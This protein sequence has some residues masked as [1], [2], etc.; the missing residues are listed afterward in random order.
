MRRR[1][2][3]L[4]GWTMTDVVIILIAGLIGIITLYPI[5]YVIS[6]SVSKPNEVLAGHVILF[7]KGFTLDAYRIVLAND[8]YFQA[9]KMTVFY[10]AVTV[11]LRVV[12]AVLLG[13]PMTRKNLKGRKYLNYYLLIPMYFGAG[14]IPQFIIVAKVLGLYNN[15]WG[16]LLPGLSIYEAILV[17]TFIKSLGDE[18]MDSAMIDGCSHI[19]TLTR[20]VFPLIK[21][22]VAVIS[23]WAIVGTWNSWFSSSVYLTNAKLHPVQMYMKKILSSLDAVKNPTLMMTL[24]YEERMRLQEMANSANQIRYAMIVFTVAPILL[25]YPYFQKY[26]TK[27]IMLGSLKG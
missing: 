19:Q 14:L 7:P 18:L 1:K 11:V 24:P 22:I 8:E 10:C 2:R 20:V 4:H 16:I 5:L 13:Y 9:I 21:P 12:C 15:V 3:K 23:M 17:R 26:F 25:V 6:C 27:G